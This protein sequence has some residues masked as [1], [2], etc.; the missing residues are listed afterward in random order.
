MLRFEREIGAYK[1]LGT[2]FYVQVINFVPEVTPKTPS[3]VELQLDKPDAIANQMSDNKFAERMGK[4]RSKL[5]KQT[6][7]FYL[8]SEP[9]QLPSDSFFD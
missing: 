2:T 4:A 3:T 9:N 5:F 7:R 6:N 1:G 8:V